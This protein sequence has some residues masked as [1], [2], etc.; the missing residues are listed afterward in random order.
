MFK[1]GLKKGASFLEKKGSMTD[2]RKH[3]QK[4]NYWEISDDEDEESGEETVRERKNAQEIEDELGSVAE[5]VPKGF[6]IGER[7]RALHKERNEFL[8]AEIEE[9]ESYKSYTVR[10]IRDGSLQSDTFATDIQLRLIRKRSTRPKKKDGQRKDAVVGAPTLIV[11]IL[12]RAVLREEDRFFPAE[13]IDEDLLRGTFTVRFLDSS[14]EQDDTPPYDIQVLDEGEPVE[15]VKHH[16][17]RDEDAG[18]EDD[19][20]DVDPSDTVWNASRRGDTVAVMR[21]INQN[22]ID[23]DSPEPDVDGPE[24]TRTPLY[25]AAERGHLDL[26]KRLLQNGAEDIDGYAMA[27]AKPKVREFLAS[28]GFGKASKDAKLVVRRRTRS[29]SGGSSTIEAVE[30]ADDQ[31]LSAGSRGGT[32][33]G[34]RAGSDSGRSWSEKLADRLHLKNVFGRSDSSGKNRMPQRASSASQSTRSEHEL[35]D[36]T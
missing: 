16:Q 29:R 17:E 36:K 34:S 25:Y 18:F 14:K 22:G 26:V 4:K 19:C 24:G 31:R 13:I 5:T 15:D 33:S 27:D 20:D 30:V 3:Q 6:R 11:G 7:V 9:V 28:Y 12:V 10:F 8:P 2:V 23:I 1:K 21:L 35:E 32:E